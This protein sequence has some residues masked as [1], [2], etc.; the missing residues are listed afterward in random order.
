MKKL[1]LLVLAAMAVIPAAAIADTTNSAD[2]AVSMTNPGWQVCGFPYGCQNRI[3]NNY[4]SF[5][6]TVKN[7]GPSAASTVT[8]TDSAWNSNVSFQS[9]SVQ[10]GSSGNPSCTTPQPG[11]VNP[12]VTCEVSSLRSKQS[13]AVVLTLK[14]HAWFPGKMNMTNQA[15]VTSSTPDSI[16]ANNTVLYSAVVQ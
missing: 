6:I 15:T 9:L 14:L 5:T 2:L 16:A 12:T 3:G 4:A 7:N 13:F 10:S 1:T 11:T 8:L